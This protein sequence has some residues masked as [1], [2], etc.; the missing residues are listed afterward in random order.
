MSWGTYAG[1]VVYQETV[2]LV[3]AFL[4]TS[5]CDSHDSYVS[6]EAVLGAH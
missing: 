5:V 4:V 1:F 6:C 3:S 2:G